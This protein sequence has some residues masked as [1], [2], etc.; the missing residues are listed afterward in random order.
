MLIVLRRYGLAF[1]GLVFAVSNFGCAQNNRQA[2]KLGAH[3]YNEP[4]YLVAHYHSK[5][6]WAT[7]YASKI[8]DS[9]ATTNKIVVSPFYV[10]AGQLSE[11]SILIED[12]IKK[13]GYL[14]PLSQSQIVE[15][16][17]RI[18]ASPYVCYESWQLAGAQAIVFGQVRI[19][20]NRRV[21]EFELIDV[22]KKERLLAKRILLHED[23]EHLVAD[24]ISDYV[25][26]AFLRN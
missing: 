14:A 7:H 11:I 16:D 10:A 8:K 24:I 15:L 26:T 23:Q 20:K 1:I 2:D 18:F 6:S 12:N 21:V 22:Y 9:A 5:C 19:Y 25:L 13:S 3:F 17:G 4:D